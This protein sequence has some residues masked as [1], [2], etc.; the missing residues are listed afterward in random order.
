[1]CSVGVWLSSATNNTTSENRHGD[2]PPSSLFSGSSSLVTKALLPLLE[3]E[4]LNTLPSADRYAPLSRIYFEKI[5]PIFPVIDKSLLESLPVTDNRRIL[6]QQGICLA[7][8]KNAAARGLLFLSGSESVLSV[9]EFGDKISSAM[10]LS[11][12]I[13]F[14][15][16]KIVLIQALSLL[17][18][19]VNAPDKG[20]L[21]SQ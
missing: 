16:D 7:A 19:F 14:V 5:H 8:S 15:S 20:D 12:E 3:Q 9:T 2:L 17:S 1:M 21:S 4:C 13:G 6:L 11:I 10:R 18:Q